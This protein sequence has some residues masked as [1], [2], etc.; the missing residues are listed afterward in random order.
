[1]A[2]T[3]LWPVSSIPEE[4]EREGAHVR[5]KVLKIFSS[6]PISHLV[7]IVATVLLQHEIQQGLAASLVH[8]VAGKLHHLLVQLR[9]KSSL[10][11]V[12]KAKTIRQGCVL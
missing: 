1:M 2:G 12:S 5:E 10:A 7:N 6:V 9:S 4:G 8:R 11:K 3:K